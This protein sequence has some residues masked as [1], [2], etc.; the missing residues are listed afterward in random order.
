M[1][2]GKILGGV[3]SVLGLGTPSSAPQQAA[4]KESKELYKK[5][6]DEAIARGEP[7]LDVGTGAVSQLGERLGLYGDPTSST[8][9]QLLGGVSANVLEQDPGYQFRR[10]QGT[11]A[12][13]RALAAQG[14][15]MSPQAV[16]ALTQYGQDLASQEYGKA[17]ERERQAQEDIFRRL[18]GTTGMGQQEAMFQSG[19]GQDYAR[20][21]A[22]IETSLADAMVAGKEAAQARRSSFFG[23]VLGGVAKGVFSDARLKENIEYVGMKNGH[24][25][26][27]FNYIGDS[28]RYS[29][30]MAQDVL[31]VTPDAVRVASSGFM[32]VDYDMLNLEMK[33]V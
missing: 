3:S 32:K 25:I 8:Y 30:V 5:M 24:K 27:E 10:D 6:Y 19:L 9:G 29:G 12:M 13:E 22:D 33:E 1:V 18:T 31:D 26:Y 17:Y 21:I 20:G 2:F 16:Q 15:T 7:F 28:K 23:N 14:R 4:A 11:Q